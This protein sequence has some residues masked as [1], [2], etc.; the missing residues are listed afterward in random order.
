M[1]ETASREL[2]TGQLDR[3]YPERFW[4]RFWNKFWENFE[5]T[6][7]TF[8]HKEGFVKNKLHQTQG[9]IFLMN[10]KSEAIRGMPWT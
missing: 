9:I 7:D 2:Q 1:E 8:W 4:N 3:K 10:N 6:G 5:N